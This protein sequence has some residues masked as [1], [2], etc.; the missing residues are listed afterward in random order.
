LVTEAYG[1]YYANTWG[2]QCAMADDARLRALDHLE[3]LAQY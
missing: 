2:D 3:A 1:Q